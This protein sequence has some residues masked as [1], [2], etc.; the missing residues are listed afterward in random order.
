VTSQLHHDAMLELASLYALGALAPQEADTFEAHLREGCRICQEALDGFAALVGPL[1]YAAPPARPRAEVRAQLLS[2]LQA[3]TGATII[4]STEGAW[5]TADVKGTL[6]KFLFRDQATG[7]FT[8]L[9]RMDRGSRYPPHR[10]TDTEEL[11]IL[12]GDLAV[13]GQVLRAGD[14]CAAMAGTIHSSPYSRDG[15]TFILMASAP[16]LL[17]E[18]WDAPGSQAG[19]AFVWA[20]K[21][22]W[23]DG[24]TEGV[25]VRPIF[26]DPARATQTALVRMRPGA[27]QPR[28]RHLTA[29]QVYM[30]EGDGHVAGHVLGP[31]DYYHMP[32]GS[33]HDVTYTE[34]GCTFLL[35]ASRVEILHA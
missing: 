34:G 18:A 14:Y 22:A 23:R 17:P 6:V 21:A 29:E 5:E 27:R 3:E 7:R 13:E 11:Y 25:A 30:L 12:E 35:I 19:L 20:S 1:G 32:A 24:P 26:S 4:R 10:H 2:R 16:E 9:V 15:C 8:A 28:H 33:M 31:G